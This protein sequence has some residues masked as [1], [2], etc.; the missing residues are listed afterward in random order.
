MRAH[1]AQP[2]AVYLLYWTAFASPNGQVGFRDDPY[3]WDAML[4]SRIEGRSAN[5]VLATR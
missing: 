2:M 5:K 4:A 1:V 3:S